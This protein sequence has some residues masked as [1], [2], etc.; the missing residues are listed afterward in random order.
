[1]EITLPTKPLYSVQDES[2]EIA[3]CTLSAVNLGALEN[4]DELEDIT[5]IIV[6]SLDSLLDYQDYP[7][8]SAQ[9]TSDNRR[10]LGI[11]VTNL[12]YYLAKNNAK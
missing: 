12:A 3:L 2:G 6:R 9:I 8:K 10:T 7:L 5:D 1:M 4:L 11:G